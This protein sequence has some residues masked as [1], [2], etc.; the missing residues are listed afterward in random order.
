MKT[1]RS[2]IIN[3]W[4]NP[5]LYD[6]AEALEYLNVSDTEFETQWQENGWEHIQQHDGVLFWEDDL[7]LMHGRMWGKV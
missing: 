7:R 2:C 5:K 4:H 6:K 1:L 3:D